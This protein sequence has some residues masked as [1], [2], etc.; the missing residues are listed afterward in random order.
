MSTRMLQNNTYR[1]NYRIQSL[2]V[3]MQPPGSS[4][5]GEQKKCWHMLEKKFD[6]FQTGRNICQHRATLAS[7]LYKRMQH[8]LPNMLAQHVAFVCTGLKEEMFHR[9]QPYF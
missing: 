5:T 9:I 2:H 7:M 3:G 6:R 4:V 8:V 1:L